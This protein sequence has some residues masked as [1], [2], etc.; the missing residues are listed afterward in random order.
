MKTLVR[1]QLSQRG[2]AHHIIL[3]LVVIACVAVVGARLFIVSHAAT[4]PVSATAGSACPK[5]GAAKHWLI[6]QSAATA[7]YRDT[8]AGQPGA[9]FISQLNNPATYE[10]IEQSPTAF[11][12]LPNATH[13]ESFKNYYDI[14]YAFNAHKVPAKVKVVLYDNEHWALTP[15]YQQQYPFKWVPMAEQLVHQNHLL[16]MS[17][18]GA[19]L[20]EVLNPSAANQYVGYLSAKENLAGLA[21]YSDIFEIQ[22]QNTGSVAQYNSF[23]TQAVAQARKANP[24]IPVLLGITAK[25]G[26]PTAQDLVNEYKDNV[27]KSDGFWYNIISPYSGPHSSIPIALPLA[28]TWTQYH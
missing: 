28:V 23:A 14:V 8:T 25:S 27:G 19:D 6:V 3:P 22:A 12:P 11:D 13:V 7:M 9:K 20:R 18:P 24:R 17:A 10:I 16:F 1:K 15:V 26:G 4:C 5:A 2:I 21:K